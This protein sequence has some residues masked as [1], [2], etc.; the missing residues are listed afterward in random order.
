M[1]WQSLSRFLIRFN[2]CFFVAAFLALPCV[3]G[4][5]S[6]DNIPEENQVR[7]DEPSDVFRSMRIPTAKGTGIDERA[8]DIERSLGYR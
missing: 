5:A 4:C 1:Y 8:R 7:E 3:F 2:I 6:W